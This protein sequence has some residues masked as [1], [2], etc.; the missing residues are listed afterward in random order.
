[1]QKETL[2]RELDPAAR[3]CC[4]YF[5]S[6]KHDSES[7]LVAL[8]TASCSRSAPPLAVADLADLV[9]AVVVCK[10]FSNLCALLSALPSL[11][12]PD[13]LFVCSLIIPNKQ[14]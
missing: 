1:M 13:D 5:S 8:I 9:P 7:P 4:T 6:G 14:A 3:I 10:S 2:L 11:F 12:P